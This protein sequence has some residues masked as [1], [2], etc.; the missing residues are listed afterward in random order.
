MITKSRGGRRHRRRPPRRVLPR[1]RPALMPRFF[2]LLV[3]ASSST[4]SSSA[5]VP[6]SASS[7][8][9]PASCIVSSS[10]SEAALLPRDTRV[11]REVRPFRLGFRL[12]PGGGELVTAYECERRTLRCRHNQWHTLLDNVV[13]IF[14]SF[15]RRRGLRT[16]GSKPPFEHHVAVVFF[17]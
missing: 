2:P 3:E 10:S 6:S 12:T 15:L 11:P 7:S 4:S 1:P 17:G 8:S 16:I 9:S 14:L 13:V 5:S